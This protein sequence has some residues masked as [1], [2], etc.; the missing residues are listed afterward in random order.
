MP[1][2]K[3]L[4]DI[5]PKKGQFNSIERIVVLSGA[6]M[7]AESGLRTF[8]DNGGLWEEY[9][10]YEVATPEAWQRD[11]DLVLRFYN[12]R[13]KQ[14][15][16][17]KPNTAHEALAELEAYFEISIVTQNVDDLHERAGSSEVLH[18]HG[19]LMKARSTGNEARIYDIEGCEL[20]M[21]DLCED[22]FQ[23]R[24]H[25]VWFGEPVPMMPKAEK[26]VNKADLLLVIGSSLS[27]YPAA[28]LVHAGSPGTPV[29][30]IDPGS[31]EVSTGLN[32]HH[33]QK[34]AGQGVAEFIRLLLGKDQ[35]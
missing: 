8:R 10:I 13:R 12:E 32:F 23:L 30:L 11:P 3:S 9:S 27:V 34:P 21:G 7:S 2:L 1:F 5:F 20:N 31:P 29:I 18:L 33:I 28:G 4:S 15:L 25:V 19:E 14:L 26:I 16:E 22:G 6:G 35:A 17:V 24:P